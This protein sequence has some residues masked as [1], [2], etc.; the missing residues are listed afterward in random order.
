M[1]V[2]CT[3]AFD[4]NTLLHNTG[5][6]GGGWGGQKDGVKDGGRS[7]GVCVGGGG[8]EGNFLKR[9]QFLYRLATTEEAALGSEELI[10][11]Y[12]SPTAGRSFSRGICHM[13]CHMI[14]LET[15]AHH[16]LLST[17]RLCKQ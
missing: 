17:T 2:D 12:Q 16:R 1:R 5:R 3:V 8:S 6:A 11:R 14:Y 4:Q 7:R 15:A 9:K 10:L 13:I